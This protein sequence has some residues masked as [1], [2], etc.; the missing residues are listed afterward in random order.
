MKLALIRQR[1]TGYGGAE[2][3]VSQLARRLMERGHEVHML[4]RAWDAAGDE[5]L[6]FHRIDSG[7]GPTAVRLRRFARNVAREVAAGGFDLVHSF[8]RTYSQD[9]FRAG[10]GC[11]REWLVR[12]ARVQ[13]AWRGW[14]DRLN[15]R[16]RAFLDL[17]AR[18]FADP[19]LKMVLVNSLRGRDEIMHHYGL[20][21]TKI[22]VLY[23]GLDRNRF[24]PGLRAQHRADV[25][26]ELK[27]AGDEPVV[28]FVGSG[29]LRKG[30]GEL[31]RALP[32]TAGNLMVI[33]RD[34]FEPFD[35]LARRVG[36]SGRVITLGP[37][38]DVERFYAAAD[39][40]CLPSWY[41]PFSNACLEAMAAGLPVVTSRE[42]GAAEAIRDG[43]NGY[44][45]GFPTDPEELAEGLNRAFELN[46]T[47]LLAANETV[48]SP[49]D[50]DKNMAGTLSVYEDILGRQ[51]TAP[52]RPMTQEVVA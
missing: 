1:Y 30:L 40:F 3:Y 51:N 52:P 5:G 23:N 48:L 17:E 11:H 31:I 42:T 39:V 28:L 8:E 16:H 26:R 21:E 36:V 35:R 50:W 34:R 47:A 32:G 33:G 7:G 49:F 25:R 24:H 19:R 44:V 46:H 43:V 9:V 45:V 29:F 6:V 20:P 10:D 15:P 4:A 41:E 12:R 2:R 38:S 27:L 37:R 13:G 18:M 22:R 14:L